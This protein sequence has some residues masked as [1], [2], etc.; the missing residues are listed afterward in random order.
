MEATFGT[1]PH[2]DVA[3]GDHTHDH[4]V[5]VADRQKTDSFVTHLL[6]HLRGGDCRT[7]VRDGGSH[8]GFAIHDDI[9]SPYMQAAFRP[10]PPRCRR[11]WRKTHKLR[12]GSGA[13]EDCVPRRLVEGGIGRECLRALE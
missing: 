5:G 3:I 4:V 2:G 13:G 1:D 6:G 7:Q 10:D 11:K 12:F 8:Y 9:D